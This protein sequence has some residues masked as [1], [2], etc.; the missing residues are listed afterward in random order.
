MNKKGDIPFWLM[1]TI[2]I[3]LSMI[4]ILLILTASGGKMQEF[5]GW[6]EDFF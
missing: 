5:L 2:V 4:V 6:L 3:L 1:M